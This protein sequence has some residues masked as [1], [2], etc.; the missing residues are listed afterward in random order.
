MREALFE[1]QLKKEINEDREAHG[2]SSEEKEGEDPKDPPPVVAALMEKEE[3]TVQ[4]KYNGSG[5]MVQE[6]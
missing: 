1:E 4:G 2:K 6:R 5:R 3:K